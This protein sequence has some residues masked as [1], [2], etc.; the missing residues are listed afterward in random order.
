MEREKHVDEAWKEASAKQKD[1]LSKQVPRPG[2]TKLHIEGPIKEPELPLE[3]EARDDPSAPPQESPEHLSPEEQ[4]TAVPQVNFLNYV[5]SLGFQAMVF[6]GEIPNP[7]TNRPE[8]SLD[9]AKFMI[10]TLAMIREKTKGNLNRQEENVLNAT[11]YELQMK[12]VE[13]VKQEG[14]QA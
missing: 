6:L 1:V 2:E 10:D 7:A 12:Y 5:T 9:H 14:Q 8:K 4:A 13:A 11:I 3:E